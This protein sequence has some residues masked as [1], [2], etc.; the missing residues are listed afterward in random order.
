MLLLFTDLHPNIRHQ[1]TTERCQQVHQASGVAMQIYF[2]A[3]PP[4]A[5]VPKTSVTCA[6]SLLGRTKHTVRLRVNLNGYSSLEIV[7]V[8]C[9][10]IHD[11]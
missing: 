6:A 2:A 11:E 10:C 1:I 3:K 5:Q 7:D 8:D 4:A 9:A